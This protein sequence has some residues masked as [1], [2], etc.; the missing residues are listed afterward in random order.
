MHKLY[1]F[2]AQTS[3][4]RY[5]YQEI[6]KISLS[7]VFVLRPSGS[8]IRMNDTLSVFYNVLYDKLFYRLNVL[9]FFSKFEPQIILFLTA[10]YFWKLKIDFKPPFGAFVIVCSVIVFWG[11]GSN[12]TTLSFI[13]SKN[14]NGLI[15]ICEQC[16]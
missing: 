9:I 7:K 10:F 2:Y 4:V 15:L 5:I 13:I 3:V 14:R 12:F 8:K 6:M 16:C 1:I 11:T